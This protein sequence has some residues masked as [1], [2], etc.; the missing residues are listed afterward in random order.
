[1]FPFFHSDFVNPVLM[2]RF[3]NGHINIT[4]KV[5]SLLSAET[6]T[7]NI[8]MNRFNLSVM[9]L[10]SGWCWMGSYD[11]RGWWLPFNLSFRFQVNQ[12]WKRPASWKFRFFRS[13]VSQ[14]N[15][16]SS[17]NSPSV[18]ANINTAPFVHKKCLICIQSGAS[19]PLEVWTKWQL[20]TYS[21]QLLAVFLC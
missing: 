9:G 10:D 4:T 14:I 15:I 12:S 6:P 18:Q 21:Q 11:W 5:G 7:E 3:R 8:Q 16:S 13:H 2:H 17:Y 1:M 20:T 19:F